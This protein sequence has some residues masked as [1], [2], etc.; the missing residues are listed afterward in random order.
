MYDIDAFNLLWLISFIG[1][2][3][4]TLEIGAFIDEQ[5]GQLGREF[6]IH[7]LVDLAY[8]VVGEEVNRTILSFHRHHVGLCVIR[9][10]ED[11]QRHTEQII[12]FQLR[13]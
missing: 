5:I 13:Q 3:I 7:H 10:A 12:G 2:D 11:V 8:I 6:I 9:P 4:H 1:F